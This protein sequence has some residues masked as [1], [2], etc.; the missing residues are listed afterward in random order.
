M[1]DQFSEEPLPDQESKLSKE[2]RERLIDDAALRFARLFY[3]QA[4]WMKE[5]E[6]K[7][8]SEKDSNSK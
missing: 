1:K 7:K 5:Q 4:V 2:E 6:Y 8:K 3:R